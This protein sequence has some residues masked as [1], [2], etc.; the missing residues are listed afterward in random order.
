MARQKTLQGVTLVFEVSGLDWDA[1][2]DYLKNDDNSGT[3]A[4]SVSA[5]GYGQE[6]LQYVSH[7]GNMRFRG[8]NIARA[9]KRQCFVKRTLDLRCGMLWM[10]NPR[11][12]ASGGGKRR[13]L[14]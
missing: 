7:D 1:V 14:I 13:S 4:D 3:G 10:R 6:A 11:P 5:W 8:P 2:V 9:E 12:R